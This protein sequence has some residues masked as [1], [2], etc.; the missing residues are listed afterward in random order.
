MTKVDEGIR[1]DLEGEKGLRE[2]VVA[3]DESTVGVL[4]GKRSFDDV[5]FFVKFGNAEKVF[6]L[7]E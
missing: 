6:E 4:P 1:Q 7:E 2:T 5:P 3:D